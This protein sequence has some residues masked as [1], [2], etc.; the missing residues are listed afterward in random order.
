MLLRNS[1]LMNDFSEVQHGL[2]CLAAAYAGP[3]GERLKRVMAAVQPDLPDI[4]QA[5]FNEHLLDV[6]QETYLVSI[7]EH[8]GGFEDTFGRLS[9]WRAYAP[10]NGVAFV[11]NNRPFLSESD[12]LQAFSSPVLYATPETFSS[13][14][15]ELVNAI[16]AGAA[17]LVE[18]GG[19][20]LHEYLTDAFRYAVQTT[21][22]PAFAEEREWRVIYAPT[23]LQRMGRM[24]PQQIDR[25]PTEI[26]SLGGVPQRVYAIPFRDH[27]EDDFVGAT[28]PDLLERILIGPTQ[29]AYAIAQ[30]FVAELATLGV[31]DPADRV[32]ITG[33]PLRV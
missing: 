4:F 15:G 14:F 7:S 10:R 32:R 6:A 8:G 29:D 26:M 19:R 21:K 18:L 22:H 24:T 16:E 17:K 20:W 3:H 12:A 25:I 30:A 9:M 28:V 2:S 31:P 13:L 33:I 23:V 11:F 27:P 1:T 5:N